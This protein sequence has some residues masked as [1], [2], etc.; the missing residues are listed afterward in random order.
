MVRVRF[1]RIGIGPEPR[2]K[3][4][5]LARTKKTNKQNKRRPTVGRRSLVR[6]EAQPADVA[7]GL[8]PL[9]ALGGA[10]ET[11]STGRQPTAGRPTRS[12]R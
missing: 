11:R 9:V 1:V 7:V 6:H 8:W 12:V 5:W 4:A 3:P 10:G 2:G